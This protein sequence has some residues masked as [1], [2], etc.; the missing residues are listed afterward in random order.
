MIPHIVPIKILDRSGDISR[1]FRSPGALSAGSKDMEKIKITKILKNC[2]LQKG[3]GEGGCL[4]SSCDDACCRYGADFDKAA[5]DIVFN[6]RELVEEGT[7]IALEKCFED[8]WSG[9]KDYLGGDSIRSLVGRSGY[10]VFHSPT[11]KG[12]VLYEL[13]FEKG[14]NRRIVPSVCRLYPLSWGGEELSVYDEGEDGDDIEKNCVCL[15]PLL[16]SSKSI[17]TTQKK[18]IAD[19]FDL[20]AAGTSGK[21]R[22]KIRS[23]STFSSSLA[24]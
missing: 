20:S 7:G 1:M 6:H 14:V 2:Y 17:F 18:E 3:F 16:C 9:E 15:D 13:A 10:C 4:G 8:E 12:C 5:H 22:R 19:I 21:K 24:R 23:R 11:G